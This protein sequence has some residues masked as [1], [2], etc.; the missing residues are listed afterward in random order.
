VIGSFGTLLLWLALAIALLQSVLPLWGYYSQHPYLL[1]SARTTTFI[2]FIFIFSAYLL[3][4]IAFVTNDFSIAYV[5][6]NSH[7][8]LPILYRLTALW[9]AHEGS[10]LLWI[11]ILNLWT[12][13]IACTQKNN[14]SLPL[15]LSILGCISFCFLSFLLFTSNP[16]LPA[17]QTI[18]PQDLNPLLQDPGFVIH[19]PM[20]YMGYVGFSVAFAMTQASLLSGRLDMNWVKVARRFTLIAWC[21]LTL[22][23]TLGSWWAYRVLGWGGFWFW[24]P[25]ENASLLPWLAGTALIHTLILADKRQTAQ[26]WAALLAIICFA[27]SL[28]GTFLVRSGLLISSHT[29][30]NDPARGVFLLILLTILIVVSLIIY[31]IRIPS[32]KSFSPH[33]FSWLSRETFLLL[34][35]ALLFV[36]MMT[37]LLGTLYPLIIDA[38]HLGSISVGAP[39]FNKVMM[40][41]VF[42]TMV[43]MGLAPFCQW[44]R[45]LQSHH[46]MSL[47]KNLLLSISSALILLWYFVGEMDI[48]A[49]IS[50]S[51]CL[52]ILLS[53]LPTLRH[54]RGMSVAH[55][56]FAILIIGIMLSSV[57]S[58]EREMRLKPGTAMTLGPYQFFF[59]DIQRIQGANYQ[60][61]LGHFDV[62]KQSRHITYLIPEKRIYTVRGMVMTKVAIHPGIF[63]DLYLALGE[64]LGDNYWSLRVY[65]KPFIRW[66]WFGGILMILGGLLACKQRETHRIPS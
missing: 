59:L 32:T 34:N 8:S 62:V 3:L 64:P 36:A 5:A 7:P 22:G 55:I 40:P 10:I 26:S 50:I 31:V 16:F 44:Q 51:L 65:Y 28:L 33:P 38:F 41:L 30:A 56:G 53:I 1:A 23:I 24:D 19:P 45:T 48:F 60:G 57:F 39:Y 6:A 47:I 58:Q 29:F 43:F 13:I 21:F 54:L 2:Q 12:I 11:F 27:L 37:V 49:M 4:T 18:V 20:L 9:G 17:L 15:I 35:S 66:I 42:I 25:V 63:R 46:W 52:W 61:I 14:G